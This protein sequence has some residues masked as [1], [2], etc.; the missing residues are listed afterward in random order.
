MANFESLLSQNTDEIERPKPLPVG[1][2]QFIVKD[3]ELGESS[4]KKTPFVRFV[5]SPVAPLEDVDQAALQAVNKWQEKSLRLDYYLTPDSQYRLK[6]FLQQ[7]GLTTTGRTFSE[8]L[9][10]A[11]GQSFI[12]H[13][14]HEASTRDPEA[15]FA[16]IDSTTSATEGNAEAAAAVSY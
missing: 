2:Y 14:T 5:A 15:V 12:G 7:L 16:T 11:K 9:V 10:E 13:V 4:Q 6:D 3:Y 8:L 1:S